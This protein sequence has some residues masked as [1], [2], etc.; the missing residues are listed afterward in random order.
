MLLEAHSG[1]LGH[2]RCT[3]SVFWLLDGTLGLETLLY[4]L[5]YNTKLYF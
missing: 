5:I 2:L 3:F 1:I 4:K